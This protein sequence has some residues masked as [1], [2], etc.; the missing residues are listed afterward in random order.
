MDNF[1]QSGRKTSFPR[2]LHRSRNTLGLRGEL[3]RRLESG[4]GRTKACCEEFGRTRI[5]AISSDMRPLRSS[6]ARTADAAE[7]ARDGGIET[8]E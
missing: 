2:I 3:A 5:N 8:R 6:V 7:Y 1:Q 4:E